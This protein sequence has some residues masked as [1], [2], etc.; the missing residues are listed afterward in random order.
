MK[1]EGSTV[2][3]SRVKKLNTQ[4]DFPFVSRG[5]KKAFTDTF[6]PSIRETVAFCKTR[7]YHTHF[8]YACSGPAANYRETTTQAERNKEYMTVGER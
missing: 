6:V 3:L 2:R 4:I 1:L 5:G 7:R 8:V